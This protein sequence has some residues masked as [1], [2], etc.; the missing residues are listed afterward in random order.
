[1]IAERVG[2]IERSLL[3]ELAHGE[4]GGGRRL[5]GLL[6]VRDDIYQ[7]I[8]VT[9]NSKVEPPVAGNSGLPDSARL[10]VLLCPQRRVT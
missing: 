3:T 10:V 8:C 4:T 5:I 9:G 2:A 6:R 1:M 7:V